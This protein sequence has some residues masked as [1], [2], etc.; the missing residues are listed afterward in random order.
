MARDYVGP[1]LPSWQEYVEA[2]DWQSILIG[3]GASR[4]VWEAFKYD[5]LFDV[6]RSKAVKNRLSSKDEELFAKLGKTRNFEAVLG[7]LITAGTVCNVLDLSTEEIRER[8]HSIRLA[9]IDA[10]HRVHVP[11]SVI[12]ESALNRIREAL[13]GYPFVFST[14]YDLLVYWAIMQRHG[15]G[16]KDFFWD[17][18]FDVA[19]TEI[20]DTC[21]KVVYLHGALHLY[22]SAEGGTYKEQAAEFS[23]LLDQ[24]GRRPDAVPLC[25][26]EGT[27]RQKL[28]A[29]ARSD[30]LS[31]ALQQFGSEDGPMVVFGHSLGKTD[32][33]LTDILARRRKQVIAVGIYPSSDDQVV[34]DKAHFISLLPN[35]TV[36]FFDSIT[37]PLGDP[38][39]L[40]KPS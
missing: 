33:H 15:D 23:N 30:Y 1:E 31:F 14:N 7:A 19:N 39:L 26:T 5:S 22:Y 37:H 24:F 6:A 38:S 11:W 35:A 21:T 29:I 36:L 27:A 40:V 32:E 13:L 20:W 9:L 28:A 34:K 2:E 18:L 12:P 8:Y 3:N 17:T 16:F 25:I 4:T 10:V